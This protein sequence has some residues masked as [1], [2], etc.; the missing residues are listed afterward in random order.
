MQD[1]HLRRRF[2]YESHDWFFHLY[3][4]HY[5]EYDT[6]PFQHEMLGLTEDE[7]VKRLVILAFRGSAK[8]TIVSLSYVL[9]SILGKPQKKFV[10]LLG[11]TQPQAR[12]HL[13]NIKDELERNPL[14]RRDLGPFEEREDEWNSSSLV[15]PKYGARITAVSCDTSMRGIRHGPHRPQLIVCDD[16][17]NLDS[18]RTRESRERLYQWVMGEVIPAGTKDTKAVF[19]GNLLHEDSLLMRLKTTIEEGKESSS[20]FRHYP[21]LDATD[22]CIWPGKFPTTADVERERKRV[23]D[24]IAWYREYLL[25]IV[26]TVDQVIRQEWIRFYDKAP[27]ESHPQFQFVASGVDLAISQSESADYTAIVSAKIAGYGEKMKIYILPNPINKRMTHLQTINCANDLAFCLGKGDKDDPYFFVEE[28]GYQKAFIE[29]L[30]EKDCQVYGIKTRAQDK[31]ARL[32]LFSHLVESGQ[33]LFPKKGAEAL[34][35]QL[36]HFGTERHDDLADSFA[37]LLMGVVEH[38]CICQPCYLIRCGDE[39]YFRRLKYGY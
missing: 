27:D 31:R 34:I 7:D 39:S 28:V 21:L 17:E 19:I 26:P 1:H 18:V 37:L 24:E 15:I 36:V 38:A 3:F 29:Q 4:P 9:W 33:V 32:S 22:R 16:L 13:K 14:L 10:L 2:G 5:T 12:Q 11:Q 30:Q 6:A 20:I 35:Q 25:R 8:S 23:G